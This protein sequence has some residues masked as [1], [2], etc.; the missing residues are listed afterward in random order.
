MKEFKCQTCKTRLYLQCTH[1]DNVFKSQES[2]RVHLSR[3]CEGLP[4]S[5]CSYAT[6]RKTDL[7]EHKGSNPDK[8]YELL[9]CSTC[10]KTSKL[11]YVRRKTTEEL[12]CQ[13]CKTRLLFQCIQ[14]DALLQAQS[15]LQYHLKHSCKNL[16]NLRCRECDFVTKRKTHLKAH[17]QSKHTE[18]R[19]ELVFCSKCSVTTK[20]KYVKNRGMEEFHCKLCRTRLHLQCM[21]CGHLLE[22]QQSMLHHLNFSCNRPS[23]LCCSMCDYVSTR[24]GHLQEHI[25]A[26]HTEG[27][28]M[29][30]CPACQREYRTQGL[31]RRHERECGNDE[32]LRCEY[33]NYSSS[34]P[35]NLQRH[36]V[37]VHRVM[38]RRKGCA[39]AALDSGG[40]SLPVNLERKSL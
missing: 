39:S 29:Y 25:I 32:L 5:E 14:C 7:M 24:K 13:I 36:Q 16:P 12:K 31:L 40:V 38:M 6:K 33:C 10:K 27:P 2:V 30:K 19:Y 15:T 17:T 3:S 4:S 9:Y 34:V 21:Q 26:K 35:T 18:M 28:K 20:L 8:R 37:R 11:A 1:C 23:N 22:T